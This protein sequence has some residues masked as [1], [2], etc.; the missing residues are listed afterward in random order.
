MNDK[1]NVIGYILI[2]FV[3][4]AVAYSLTIIKNREKKVTLP[5]SYQALK[6]YTVNEYI[7]VY[8]SDEDMV[9][10]YFND[11]LNKLIYTPEDAYYLLDKDYMNEEYPTYSSFYSDIVS[12]RTYNVEISTF[13]KVFR[14]GYTIFGVYDT[15]DNFYAFKT[16]GVM[17]YSVAFDDY[18]IEK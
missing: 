16:K 10:I 14:D 17:Q 6:N 1:K 3:V 8:V 15:D 12:S 11:F 2:V 9:K 4:L 18:I 7:P 13:Y 5:D